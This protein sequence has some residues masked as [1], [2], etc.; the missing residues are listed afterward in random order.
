[1]NDRRRINRLECPARRMKRRAARKGARVQSIKL[2]NGVE[3]PL[4]GFGTWDVR[5]EEGER[6][7][8]DAIDEG[9]RLIDTARMYDNEEIVGNALRRSGAD[10]S[11]MFVTTKLN[12]PCASYEKAKAGVERALELLQTDYVDLLLIHE[13]YEQAAEMYLALEEALRDGKARA[14]GVSNFDERRYDALVRECSVVPAVNQVES[15]VYFS[16]MG[17]RGHL[18]AHGTR[19][20]AWGSFTEGRRNIFADPVLSRIGAGHRKTAGQV[21]L[22]YLVQN[23]IGVIP[24]TARRERMRENRDVFDFELS[25]DEMADIVSLDG[26]KSLFG[27]Y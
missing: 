19:M 3:M 4:V 27:W 21:A 10:R 13:P 14:I 15:H 23:G 5:G 8:L 18:E 2:N 9:Y 12:R 7:L 16:Q 6:I 11:E 24:K 25:A 22:R 26:G 20:Q 17:L 1:M